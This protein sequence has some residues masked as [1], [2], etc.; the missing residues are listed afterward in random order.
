MASLI[1]YDIDTDIKILN[2]IHNSKTG[3]VNI[4]DLRHQLGLYQARLEEHIDHLSK[5]KIIN[6][7][8]P[9]RC[10]KARQI[11]FNESSTYGESILFLVH[12]KNAVQMVNEYFD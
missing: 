1:K 4:S 10:G 8:R 7:K 9:E 6:D 5:W 2:A 3:V 12:L 11:S